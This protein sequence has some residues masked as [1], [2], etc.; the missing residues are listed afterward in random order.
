MGI[1]KKLIITASGDV[2]P[3]RGNEQIR[4]WV[5]ANGGKWVSKIQKGVTHL[6]CSKENWKKEVDAVQLAIDL[7][8]H[9]VSYDW[10]E[11]SL[12]GRRKLAE[13]KYTW[14]EVSKVRRKTKEIK[15]LSTKADSMKFQKGCDQARKD[16]GSDLYHTYLDNTGFEYNITLIR[17]NLFCNT[18][19]RYNL[20][21]FESNTKPHVYCTFIRYSPPGGTEWPSASGVP[22][23]PGQ[24]GRSLLNGAGTGND[25]TVQGNTENEQEH[26]SAQG[27]TENEQEHGPEQPAM[28]S[29]LA[30]AIASIAPQPTTPPADQ[31]Y[32]T[33]LTPLGSPFDTAFASFR[34]AFHTLTLLAWHE[35][36]DTDALK[37][38][39][40]SR[41]RTLNLEPFVYKRP[42]PGLPIGLMPAI[43]IPIPASTNPTWKA[44]HAT[45]AQHLGVTL[46]A[47]T[48]PLS[49][50][51]AIGAAIFREEEARKK[52][53]EDARVAAEEIARVR[54]GLGLDKKAQKEK[55]PNWN[56]PLFN[57]VHGRPRADADGK[58]VPRVQVGSARMAKRAFLG[59]ER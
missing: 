54:K 5:D 16:T 55:K 22:V 3:G 6:I 46:P 52:S 15:R 10:L 31:S 29:A 2:G 25:A 12:Q 45:A 53:A 51:H 9:V 7:G 36:F 48:T 32:R 33:L 27:S 18:S 13:K 57:G 8:A 24:I 14:S 4:K 11:D 40:K 28:H 50:Q 42:D 34:H 58:E 21:L 43:P 47:T 49:E 23:V 17:M 1:L 19:A 30:R 41:A 39:Q 44:D 37:T 59:F 26:G 35:R 20:R 38:L 56:K